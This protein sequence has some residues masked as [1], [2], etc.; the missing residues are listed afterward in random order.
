MTS[1]F[2][3]QQLLQLRK[4]VMGHDIQSTPHEG[5]KLP[6]W[7]NG[8]DIEGSCGGKDLIGRQEV[9]DLCALVAGKNR[10]RGLGWIMGRRLQ[11]GVGK[12]LRRRFVQFVLARQTPAIPTTPTGTTKATNSSRALR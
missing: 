12:A 5:R 3:A 6:L 2:C 1:G 4:R 10:H 7:C 11:G 9:R 8:V